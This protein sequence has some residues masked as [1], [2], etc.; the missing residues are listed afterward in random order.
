MTKI[1]NR[2]AIVYLSLC[3]AA[4]VSTL[5]VKAGLHMILIGSTILVGGLI[6]WLAG[7]I[8]KKRPCISEH[9]LALFHFWFYQFGTPALLLAFYL[10][11][12][13]QAPDLALALFSVGGAFM[14]LGTILFIIVIRQQGGFMKKRAGSG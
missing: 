10:T 8:H 3:I 2:T 12:Y 1:W 11:L 5:F 4:W 6:M 9:I 14:V 13:G 7:L